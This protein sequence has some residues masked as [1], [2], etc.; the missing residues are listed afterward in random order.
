MSFVVGGDA[1]YGAWKYD[2]LKCLNCGYITDPLF[3]KKQGADAERGCSSASI[4]GVYA[5]HPSS[6]QYWAYPKPALNGGSLAVIAIALVRFTER[7]FD[8]QLFPL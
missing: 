5:G 3:V 8:L 6:S 4:K 7:A 2:G 1:T